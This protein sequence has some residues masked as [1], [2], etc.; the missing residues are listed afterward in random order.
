VAAR[1]VFDS[2]GKADARPNQAWSLEV[3]PELTRGGLLFLTKAL[4]VS[5]R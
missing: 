1:G 4:H 5:R 2:G 3:G